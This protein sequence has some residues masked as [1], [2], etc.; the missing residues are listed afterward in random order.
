MPERTDVLI[1]GGGPSGLI[2]ALCLARAGV[3]S[4]VVERRR[5]LGQH[6]KAHEVNARTLEILDTLA[7]DRSRLEALAAPPEDAARVVFCRGI[8]EELGVLDLLEEDIADRYAAHVRA[9]VP[10]L[11]LSQVELE[12][13]LRE[14]VD[15]EPRIAF[16]EGI[17]WDG[18]VANDRHVSGLRDAETGVITPL[19]HRFL[20]A[21]DGA[22]SRVRAALG[23]AME[24]PEE[25]QRFV[26]CAF[27]ADLSGIVTTRGKLYWILH[28]GAAGTLIAHHVERCWVFHVPFEAGLSLQDHDEAFFAE[29]LKIALG[30]PIS[31]LRIRSICEWRMSAQ[32]AERFRDGNTFLVG[33]AAHRFP[34]TGG[35]G[36]NTGAA[37]AHNL[38]WKLAAVLHDE[39]TPA[40]LDTY[41]AERRPVAVA[42]CTESH[43]NYERIFEVVRSFGLPAN[44]LEVRSRLR[45]WLAWIPPLRDAVSR[46]VEAPAHWLMGRFF[47]SRGVREAVTHSI[48]RQLPHFDRLGLDIGYVYGGAAEALPDDPVRDYAPS[49]APGARLPHLW[50]D[51][52]ETRSTHDVLRPNAF[53]LLVGDAERWVPAVEQARV[54]AP[55]RIVPLAVEAQAW[56]RFVSVGGL[57]PNGAVLV[58]PDGHVAWSD[59]SPARPVDSLLEACRAC[60]LA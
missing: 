3:S 32:V 8:R 35:L 11:N 29:R 17:A 4:R 41:E 46:L 30:G 37:D 55:I 20:L 51:A 50:L 26:S 13:V 15:R 56:E 58:R 6:P 52:D 44:S 21:A 18:F 23:I 25:L 54:R 19:E 36:L 47:R 33:D 14:A 43:A 10:Y 59:P 16:H 31:D 38:A 45:A 7:I 28:P 42:N 24:G 53:T 48:R 57:G 39:A 5:G 60:H 1:V 40:L 12:A 9:G 2:A 22:A 49:M 34:P 27:D